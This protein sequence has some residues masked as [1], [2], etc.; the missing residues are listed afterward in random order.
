MVRTVAEPRGTPAALL[1]G[2]GRKP[3]EEVAERALG[4]QL[5]RDLSI[6]ARLPEPL[7]SKAVG[8]IIAAVFVL[9]DYNM[10]ELLVDGW[11]EHHELT[12]AAWHTL[13]K[14]GSTELVALATHSIT[15]SQKPSID[16]I[17]NGELVATVELELTLEFDV[18][19]A[20]AG[21]TAGL[22]T[23]LH[24]GRCD[25]TGT[26]TINGVEATQKQSRI[27]LPGVISLKQGIRLLSEDAY[28]KA[29]EARTEAAGT[30][31]T[32][33]SSEPETVLMRP[34]IS[35]DEKATVQHS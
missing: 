24:S 31:M 4:P 18:S 16:L 30:P 1:F 34:N 23:A 29:S 21:I 17:F 28:A 11:R 25:I 33:V 35:Q 32:S 20:V 26:L 14:P 6:L 9:L 5:R 13:A 19:A 8:A 27:E 15:V 7:R 2:A 12:D 3:P 10:T 22:L